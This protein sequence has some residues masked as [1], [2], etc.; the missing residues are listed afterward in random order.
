MS[1]IETDKADGNDSSTVA[2]TS[3]FAPVNETERSVDV[4]SESEIAVFCVVTLKAVGCGVPTLVPSSSGV[5]GTSEL[6]LPPPPHAVSNI[7]DINVNEATLK[8]L[9]GA[10]DKL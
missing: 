2:D 9:E 6:L 7:A 1:L 10:Y 4:F 8:I 3:P 5:C